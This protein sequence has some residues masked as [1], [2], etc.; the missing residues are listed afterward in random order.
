M[1]VKTANIY[2]RIEPEVK[3]QAEAILNVLG[4]PASCAINMFYKQIILHKGLPFEVA[5]P[6]N[7][8]PVSMR[9]LTGEQVDEELEK[10]LEDIRAGKTISAEES[11]KKSTGIITY[12]IPCPL[13]RVAKG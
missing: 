4:I 13:S 8:V 6:N 3:E 10:G 12:E 9:S 2:A 11:I 5:I 7:K 1:S